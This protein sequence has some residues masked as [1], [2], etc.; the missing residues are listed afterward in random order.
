MLD[1]KYTVGA[2]RRLVL[3]LGLRAKRQG[4][5]EPERYR[6]PYHVQQ[7][8]KTCGRAGSENRIE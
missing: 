8:L 4:R 2:A 5:V 7:Q 6:R 1:V 3:M